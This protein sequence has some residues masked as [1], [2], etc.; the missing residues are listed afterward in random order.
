MSALTPTD[1]PPPP[2][3]PPDGLPPGIPVTERAAHLAQTFIGVTSILMA[4]CLITFFTR[5]YQRVFPVFKM[6]LDDWFI[7]VGFVGPSF[8][9]SFLPFPI[10]ST[11]LANPNICPDPSNS[12]LVP[13]L[14]AHGPQTRLHPLLPRHRS[15]QALLARHPRLGVGHDVH[16]DLD[17]AYTLTNPRLRKKV[18]GILVHHHRHPGHL[19]DR[20]HDILP[21]YRVPAVAGGLGCVDPRW[22]VCTGGGNEGRF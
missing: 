6:G 10:I 9:P 7:I 22:E 4:L 2:P 1:A 16:Q 12:R 21:G 13:P 20:Q 19:R 11:A 3:P 5:I 15:R 17:C 8:L 18:E 14:P